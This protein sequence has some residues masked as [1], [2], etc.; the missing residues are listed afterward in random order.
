MADVT[1]LGPLIEVTG[2]C[3]GDW[4]LY[5]GDSWLLARQPVGTIVATVA[6]P[7]DIAWRLFTRGLT[8]EDAREHVRV[9]GDAGLGSHVLNMLTI[10]G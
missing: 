3:G 9:T 7:Q 10:V 1:P 6:I 4:H 2:E 5:R 8:R